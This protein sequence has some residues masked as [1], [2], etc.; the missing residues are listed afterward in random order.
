MTT[1]A[2][3]IGVVRQRYEPE[4]SHSELALLDA[5]RAACSE[6]EG[7]DALEITAVIRRIPVEI[8]PKRTT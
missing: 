3:V 6:Q 5:L 7:D 1:G 4:N 8:D 2:S